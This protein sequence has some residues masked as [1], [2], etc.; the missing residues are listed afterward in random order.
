MF[1]AKEMVCAK[2]LWLERAILKEL[3]RGPECLEGE[4]CEQGTE[5]V[6]GTRRP[7]SRFLS[8]FLEWGEP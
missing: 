4:E 5:E 8:L 6:W 2:A 3:E 1:L 7:P